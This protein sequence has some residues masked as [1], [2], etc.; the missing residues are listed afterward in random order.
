MIKKADN[1]LNNNFLIR[2]FIPSLFLLLCLYPEKSSSS[3]FGT[4]K[5]E[6]NFYYHCAI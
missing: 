4:V 6:Y 2:F 5:T 1:V 3:G